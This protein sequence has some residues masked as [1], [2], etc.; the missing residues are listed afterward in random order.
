MLP[1][2]DQ[3]MKTYDLYLESGPKHMKTMVHVLDLLGCVATGPTTETA[4]EAT[5][6]SI[7]A[8]LRLMTA[9]GQRADPDAAFS[10]RVAEHITEGTWLGNGS[11]YVAFGPD[12]DPVSAKDI[13]TLVARYN[14]MR[15]ML[16]SWAESRTARQLE[17]AKSGSRSARKILAH[18]AGSGGGYLSPVVG[19]AKGFSALH[20]AIER[21]EAP[22]P[23]GI[24]RVA[25][26][27]TEIVR[28]TTPSQRSAVIERPKEIRTLRK[29]L[30]RMLEHDF[31]HLL[32]LSRMPGGPSW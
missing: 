7:R 13:S 4:L 16:A 30:R 23:E 6:D 22:L 10:T 18:V 17:A 26:M 1:R 24:R 27:C 28:A 19:G 15:E 12:L 3:P 9:A 29:A 32:E 21:G 2:I 8:Y 14:A 25:A 11:P 20:S 31:E 5:P